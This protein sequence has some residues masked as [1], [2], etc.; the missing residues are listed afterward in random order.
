MKALCM[1]LEAAHGEKST[2]CLQEM[3]TVYGLTATAKMFQLFLLT[4]V[5]LP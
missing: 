1:D 4:C 2:V 3:A 5:D